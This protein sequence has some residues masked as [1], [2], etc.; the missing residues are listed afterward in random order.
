MSED[1]VCGQLALDRLLASLAVES[2]IMDQHLAQINGNC[3]PRSFNNSN[4]SSSQSSDVFTYPTPMTLVMKDSNQNTIRSMSNGD[5]ASLNDVIANL[6]D[7][8]RHETLRQLS[9]TNGNSPCP[10]GTSKYT[11]SSTSNTVKRLASESDNSSSIS[12]CFSERSNGVSWNDQVQYWLLYD[13]FFFN[14]T[15]FFFISAYPFAC[16]HYSCY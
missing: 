2:D 5:A 6:T 15:F 7:F 13:F 9:L 8:T 12:P 4:G 1:S 10:N 14:F 16:R 3:S 11:E